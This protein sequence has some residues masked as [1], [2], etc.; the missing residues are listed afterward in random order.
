MINSL[1][2]QQVAGELGCKV[3]WI[4][5]NWRELCSK[6]GMPKPV[7]EAGHLAWS[8]AQFYAWLDRDLPLTLRAS[9]AAYR[10]AASAYVSAGNNFDTMEQQ[11]NWRAKLDARFEKLS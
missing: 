2:A 6:K 11:Q 7:F 5:A 8:A 4:Y 10:A 1:S 3:R 9:A